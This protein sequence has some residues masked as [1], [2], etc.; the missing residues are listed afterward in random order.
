MSAHSYSDSASGS[1]L[2]ISAEAL[3]QKARVICANALLLPRHKRGWFRKAS[4]EELPK[5]ERY[6]V[7]C[8]VANIGRQAQKRNLR[9]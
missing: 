4:L 3:K 7:K 8:Y 9:G 6:Y 1:G 5:D 2:P